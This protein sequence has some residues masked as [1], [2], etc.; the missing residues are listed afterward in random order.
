MK[1]VVISVVVAFLILV[2]LFGFSVVA[3]R[4][5]DFDPTVIQ[6]TQLPFRLPYYLDRVLLTDW[7]RGIL[8][9]DRVRATIV[10]YSFNLV[11]YSGLIYF[12]ISVREW[13]LWKSENRSYEN[14][15]EN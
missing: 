8:F 11:F 9:A 13:I 1:R 12:V 10:V 4:I 3:I 7:I 6:L 15:S 14:T 5:S 2:L